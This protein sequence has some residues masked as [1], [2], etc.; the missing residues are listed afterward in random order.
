[1][2]LKEMGKFFGDVKTRYQAGDSE[3]FQDFTCEHLK[4]YKNI[5]NM[6]ILQA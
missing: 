3:G 6:Q 4:P 1:M 2:L 5:I